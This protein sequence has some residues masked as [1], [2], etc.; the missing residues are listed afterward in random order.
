[1]GP[2]DIAGGSASEQLRLER[3]RA[4]PARF[5]SEFESDIE[6]LYLRMM[7]EPVPAR[8]LNILRAGMSGAKT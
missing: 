6:R 7:D 2:V 4:R 5:L 8:L 1:M 3:I